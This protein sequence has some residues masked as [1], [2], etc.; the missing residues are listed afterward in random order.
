MDFNAVLTV[1]FL[2]ERHMW[3]HKL[4][5]THLINAAT[6]PCESRKR[7]PASTDRTARRQFQATGQP[8]SQ[9]QDSDVMTSQLPRCEAKWVQHRCF[10]WGS[11]PLDADIKGMELPPA[12]I[13]IPLER[14]LIVLQLCCWQFLFSETLQQTFRP[15]LSKL[16]KRWQI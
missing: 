1:R 11:V 12:N 9:M 14:Q 16:S 5:S 4:H 13:L 7:W 2:N 10:Q 6:L 15:L 3:R 8:V